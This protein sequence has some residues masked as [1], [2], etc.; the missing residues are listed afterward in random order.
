M[1]EYP[2]TVSINGRRYERAVPATL[3]LVDFIRDEVGLTGTKISCEAQVCGVCTVLV[4]GLPISSCGYLAIDVDGCDVSTVEG[5]ADG[6]QLSEFQTTLLRAG[7][8]Q[9]G[10]CTPGF[11]MT[12]EALKRC[13]RRNWDEEEVRHALEGNICR[14]T[15]YRQIIDATCQYLGTQPRDSGLHAS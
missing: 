14:C 7:G 5:M 13:G 8:S 1:N 4:D 2:I 10:Y 9:C 11:V 12:V 6:R 3:R 15:G